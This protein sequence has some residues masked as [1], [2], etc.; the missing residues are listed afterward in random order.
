ML[1]TA[2]IQI[3]YLVFLRL[4]SLNWS[5]TGHCFLNAEIKRQYHEKCN[6]VGGLRWL[7][8]N[9]AKTEAPSSLPL[10]LHH[11]VEGE[12]DYLELPFDLVISP[13]NAHTH[14]LRLC[15]SPVYPL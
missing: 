2:Q 1:V 14:K 7:M 8:G 4:S 6:T 9:N 3:W 15:L 10:K 12:T 11:M 13:T 5:R